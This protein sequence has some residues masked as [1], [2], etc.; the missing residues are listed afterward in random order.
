MQRLAMITLVVPDYDEAI[1]HYVD[2]LGFE[3]M[4]DTALAADKRWVVVTPPGG[5]GAALLLA[6]AATDPQR[7]RI[8]DQTGGRVAF[9]LH[10]D[11]F[12]A[13]VARLRRAGVRLLGTPRQEKYGT[14]VVFED[15]YGNRWDLIERQPG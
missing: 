7:T 13:D 9:F 6:R 3:L 4:E 14:V 2:D 11:S 15:R 8:G 12:E 5:A 10:T 1:A